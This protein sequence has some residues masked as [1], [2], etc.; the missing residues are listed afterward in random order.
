MGAFHIALLKLQFKSKKKHT[1][2]NQICELNP[3]LTNKFVK[4]TNYFAQ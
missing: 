4:Q 3:N 1:Q 2:K